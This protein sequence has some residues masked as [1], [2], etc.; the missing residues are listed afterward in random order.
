MLTFQPK[1][2]TLTFF[3]YIFIYYHFRVIRNY[4]L[5]IRKTLNRKLYS[6]K[7]LFYLSTSVKIQFFKTFIMPYFD[8]CLS[9][10]IY[11][12]KSTIQTLSNCFNNCIYKLFKFKIETDGTLASDDD[13]NKFN[14][15]LQS[16]GLFS[17]QHRLLNKVM[18]FAH[19]IL[20]NPFSPPILKEQLQEKMCNQGTHESD[21]VAL[22]NNRYFSRTVTTSTRYGHLTFSYFYDKLFKSFRH[23]NFNQP[24]EI[25]KRS[26][27]DNLCS[28]FLKFV[29]NF[30]NFDIS[31][32]SYNFRRR[33]PTKTTNRK[34]KK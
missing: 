6:I 21:I 30:A 12:P 10:L 16:Y 13:V 31:Y 17:F 32:K 24:R 15:H 22:R 8:Y 29:K 25:F 5:D 4:I 20:N 23:C 2:E 26:L 27:L 28:N 34:T 33:K 1:K 7:R 14:T 19:N 9:L 11:F 3:I 18:I